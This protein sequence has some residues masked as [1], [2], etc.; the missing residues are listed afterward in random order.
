LAAL[1]VVRLDANW[2]EPSAE[3]KAHSTVERL[4]PPKVVR[5]E[6]SSAAMRAAWTVECLAGRSDQ[7]LALH[8]AAWMA[9]LRVEQMEHWRVVRSERSRAVRSA[10]KWAD[11]RAAESAALKAEHWDVT[12]AAASVVLRAAKMGS[13]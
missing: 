5:S 10:A 1:T 9:E 6:K 11:S 4:A 8:S 7:K 2:A 13:Y 3:L 12:W